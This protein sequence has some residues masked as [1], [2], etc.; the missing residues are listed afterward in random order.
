MRR[1]PPAAGGEPVHTFSNANAASEGTIIHAN[2]IIATDTIVMLNFVLTDDRGEMLEQSDP[3]IGYLHGGY[4]EIFPL[5]EA[6]LQG[7][8]VG[9]S[10]SITLRPEDAF[11]WFDQAL[12]RT[13]R[14]DALP[15]DLEVGMRFAGLPEGAERV[16]SRQYIIKAIT[17]KTVELDGN[18]PL[19]GKTLIFSCSVLDVRR[20]TSAELAERDLYDR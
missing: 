6:A 14:R 2:M 4:N 7:K 8:E 9:H 12:C 18:H 10:F 19:V 5:V 20:A 1:S 17:D 13:V 11:G 3:S 16:E 15:V